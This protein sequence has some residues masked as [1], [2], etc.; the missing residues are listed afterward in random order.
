M[1]NFVN[2]GVVFV[3]TVRVIRHLLWEFN[4]M[5]SVIRLP[6]GINGN[7]AGDDI[8]TYCNR[9]FL[10]TEDGCTEFVTFHPVT[11]ENYVAE[12]LEGNGKFFVV[13]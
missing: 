9:R 5:F 6:Q 7:A 1:S 3:I 2:F 10:Y 13:N 4:N 8:Q 11:N 12:F